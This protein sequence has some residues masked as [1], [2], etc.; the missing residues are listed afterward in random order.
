MRGMTFRLE[1]LRFGPMS[2]DIFRLELCASPRRR[3]EKTLL[4]RVEPRTIFSAEATRSNQRRPAF[5]LRSLL[6][7]PE[8]GQELK[9]CQ[10]V[11][12]MS[13]SVDQYF[14]TA[15]RILHPSRPH[16]NEPL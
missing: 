8:V 16:C 14:I 12:A 10:S 1:L 6:P 5:S 13:R 3:E 11:P 4:G 2:V 15:Y 7:Q 9:C